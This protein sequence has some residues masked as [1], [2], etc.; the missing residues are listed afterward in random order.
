MS[1]RARQ[2][3]V[4][5]TLDAVGGVWTY[6]LTLARALVARGSDVAFLGFGPRPGPERAREARWLGQLDW[7]DAPLDWQATDP[8]RLAAVGPAIRT[9][10]RRYRADLAL[11]AAPSQAVGVNA[12][13]P[14][15]SVAH[16]CLAT[17][18]RA[19]RDTEVP[20][21]IAWKAEATRAGL[22]ACA[23]VVAPTA[24][25]AALLRRCYPGTPEPAV[26]W[27]GAAPRIPCE[28][29]GRDTAPVAVARWWDPGKG[30]VIL[31]A[32]AAR[33]RA[34]A[35]L[36]GPCEV[37]GEYPF[38]PRH[39]EAIGPLPHEAALA[40]VA[41]APFLIAPSLYEPFGLAVAEAASMGVPLLL[42]DIPTFRELWGGA[43]LFYPARDPEA[44]AR[45]ADELAGD[46]AQRL[47]LGAAAR[48]RAERY[49][50]A[51]QAESM[52]ALFEG[53]RDARLPV[54][55]EV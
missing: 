9:A 36:I 22:R 32:A 43:A 8:D 54:T 13:A 42:A 41:R 38:R 3:R 16:S 46:A 20:R 18:F 35:R 33:M 44:L 31:D 53:L 28:A 7:S 23:A 27:N 51:R 34:P 40:M 5:M 45:A 50:P 49:R 12:D 30:G 14:L 6:A 21:E 1:A 11:L 17:W 48:A 29:A 25:H 47:R 15:V 2:P 19:V 37:P 24:A 4:L 26:I 10:L 55:A 52:L 39:T